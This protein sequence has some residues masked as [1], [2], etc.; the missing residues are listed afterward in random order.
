MAQLFARIELRGNPT[1]QDYNK[2]HQVMLSMNWYQVI[3]PA[4]TPLAHAM[5]QAVFDIVPNVKTKAEQ[6]KEQIESATW[7]R[8]L[9]LVIIAEFWWQT[10]D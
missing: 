2:L 10:A 4:S 6:L 7:P 9:V 1:F 8:A 5:Y 3:G